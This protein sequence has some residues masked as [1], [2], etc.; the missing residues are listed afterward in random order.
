MRR[1]SELSDRE[2]F[3]LGTD[4][5]RAARRAEKFDMPEAQKHWTEEYQA[6]EREF[7]RRDKER[8]G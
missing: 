7:K 4:N 6:V 8:H 5:I 3:R 1:K 2:L